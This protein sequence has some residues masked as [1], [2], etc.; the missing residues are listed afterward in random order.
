M[1]GLTGTSEFRRLW[2]SFGEGLQNERLRA[3]FFE[4]SIFQCACFCETDAG[5]NP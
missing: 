1:M 2:V 3:G 5:R 4:V